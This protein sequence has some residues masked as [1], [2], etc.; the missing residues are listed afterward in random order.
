MIEQTLQQLREDDLIRSTEFQQWSN[1]QQRIDEA[2]DEPLQRSIDSIE[3]LEKIVRDHLRAS[4][5]SHC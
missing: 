5:H 4:R 2:L 1:W 3:A